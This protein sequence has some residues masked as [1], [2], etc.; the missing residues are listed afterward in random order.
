MRKRSLCK[1]DQQRRH[2][3]PAIC[4]SLILASHG[5][6]SV[7]VSVGIQLEDTLLDVS[8][9]MLCSHLQLLLLLISEVV[10]TPARLQRFWNVVLAIKER[11][12]EKNGPEEFFKLS[13]TVVA[14][15]I[16]TRG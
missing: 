6:L 7:L 12:A 4:N 9:K 3:C 10:L 16:F 11:V 15:G 5:A 2:N 8:G 14:C 1:T 13:E